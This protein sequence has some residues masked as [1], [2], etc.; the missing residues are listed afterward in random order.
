MT[1]RLS[2]AGQESATVGVL[3][4]PPMVFV[5]PKWFM[6]TFSLALAGRMLVLAELATVVGT[7]AFAKVIYL[8]WMIDSYSSWFPYLAVA[9]GL[10]GTLGLTYKQ[11]GLYDIER[12]AGPN[13][14]LGKVW[15]G[16]AIS[17]FILFGA[18]YAVKQSEALSRG[19]VFTWIVLLIALIV[20]VRIYVVHRITKGLATGRFRRRIAIIGTSDYATSLATHVAKKEGL[21][22]TIDLYRSE[23]GAVDERFAGSVV[24]LEKAMLVQPYDQVIVAIPAAAKDDIRQIVR[25]LGAYTTELCLCTDLA[26][27]PIKAVGARQI[28][29][30]RA[31][32]V[33][34]LPGSERS[35]LTK[36]CL[37]VVI[38]TVA[39]T[40]LS[41]I[42]LLIALAIKLDSPGPV[43]FRQRRIG[44]NNLVFRIFKFRSMSVAEDGAVVKQ[45]TRAD[46]RVTRVG[47]ILRATSADE[48]PQLINV[49]L[50]EMSLVGPRPHAIAHDQAFEQQFDLFSCRRRVKPGITGWAQVNGFRGETKSPDDLRRRMEHDLYY[51]DNWSIWFDIEILARTFGVFAKGAY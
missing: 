16:L 49:L 7:A 26:S 8:D 40:L 34:L 22:G 27:Q 44:Q 45:A 28:G 39:L 32:V 13:I 2:N 23:A 17:F 11:M 31:D 42:F 43:L 29:S 15:G 50:G 20:P 10:A 51:I 25:S 19:W 41:P 18:L 24:D 38:A 48:L 46:P 47:R 35:W 4:E 3:D 5:D 37:D 21:S 6:P 33:H 30:V 12:L 9:I 1:D 14:N 36:R